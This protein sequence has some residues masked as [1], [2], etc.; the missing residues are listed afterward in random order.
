MSNIK[1]APGYQIVLLLKCCLGFEQSLTHKIKNIIH[2]RIYTVLFPKYSFQIPVGEHDFVLNILQLAVKW[3]GG[4]E[5]KQIFE[6]RLRR[7][8]KNILIA[9]TALPADR[10]L[11]IQIQIVI[12]VISLL[13]QDE[14][15]TYSYALKFI[16]LPHVVHSDKYL[17]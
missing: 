14:R 15:F 13:I 17:Q 11:I 5:V 2:F 6:P 9:V 4:V 3:C 7:T 12:E 8:S 10:H 16:R 1:Y